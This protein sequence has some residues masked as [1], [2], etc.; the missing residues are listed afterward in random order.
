MSNYTTHLTL[1]HMQG[2][3]MCAV[4]GGRIYRSEIHG[5]Q[6]VAR[7]NSAHKV[8]QRRLK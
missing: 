7:P 4:C 5:L 2:R 8:E 6:H 3:K 1:W